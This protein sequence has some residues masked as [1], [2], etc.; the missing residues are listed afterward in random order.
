[1]AE[2]FSQYGYLVAVFFIVL[3]AF[4]VVLNKAAKAYSK[5]F[6]TVNEQKKQLEYMTNLKNKYRNI[7][8]DELAD[9]SDAEILEGF[10]LLTQIDMQKS[11]DMESYFRT[12][13][14]EKQ[15][16]YVLDVF[17]EDG[18]AKEFYS[19]NG[20]IL[21]GIII[22][23]LSAV[24]MKDFAERLSEIGKMYSKDDESISFDSDTIDKFDQEINDM[25][26]LDE[27]RAKTAVF[28][29]ENFNLL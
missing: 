24:G 7:T 9:C 4:V 10:A 26:V 6:N 13:P 28:I 14:K 18:S 1:M 29:K 20:E 8:A 22:D 19:Q 21:T 3:V 15:Y 17:V 2:W 5:H 23:A 16:I 27:I 12:L 11:D 25:C